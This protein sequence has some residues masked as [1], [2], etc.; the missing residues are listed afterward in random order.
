[1]TV[2]RS[3]GGASIL[4]ISTHYYPILGGVETHARDVATGLRARGRRV[5]VL[6]TLVDQMS[7]RVA[8]IDRVPVVRTPP[9]AGRRRFSK[10]LFLPV[11]AVVRRADGP[12][13]RRHLLS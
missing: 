12:A 5:T 9:A 1:V 8:R 11:A 10:W 3:D 13:L 2:H 4:L 7:R 6:T